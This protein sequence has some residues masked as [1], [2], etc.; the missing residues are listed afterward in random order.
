V[1]KRNG[2]HA[3]LGIRIAP[4]NKLK[5][6]LYVGLAASRP[7]SPRELRRIETLAERLA[8]HLDNAGLYV[9]LEEKSGDLQ[10][11]EEALTSERALRER[12]MSILAHDLRRPLNVAKVGALILARQPAKLAAGRALA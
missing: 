12:F 11:K 1:L 4:H 5:G 9:D 6:V 2:I 7:F 3:L 8:L 10:E